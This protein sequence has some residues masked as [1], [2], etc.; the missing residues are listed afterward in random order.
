MFN[1]FIYAA[2]AGFAGAYLLN[3]SN[4]VHHAAA[5]APK[6]IPVNVP[7]TPDTACGGLPS[8]KPALTLSINGVAFV[9]ELDSGASVALMTTATA[10]K[11]RLTTLPKGP[12]NQ[13][14]F[15]GQATNNFQGYNA[16]VVIPG[17]PQQT[18]TF[19]T[20]PQ[21]G[22]NILPTLDL[23]KTYNIDLGATNVT[24]THI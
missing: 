11:T 6:T 4:I 15:T 12:V 14:S 9:A 13:L 23:N 8:G 3:S 20:G 24:F 21:I 5:P 19:F 2:V 16:P 17:L 1:N 10:T 18:I 22:C 7:L